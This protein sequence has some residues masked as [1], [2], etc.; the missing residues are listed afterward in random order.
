MYTA[1]HREVSLQIAIIIILL[2]LS[3]AFSASETAFTSLSMIQKKRL[4]QDRSAMGKMAYGICHK[5]DDLITTVLVGN[6]IVNIAESALVTS[7]VIDLF[8]NEFVAIATGI[9]TVVILIFGE[10]F[11]KQFALNHNIGVA[12]VMSFPLRFFQIILFPVVWLFVKISKLFTALFSKHKRDN[13]LSVD[14]LFD[15]IDVAK[16]EGV[17]DSY[18]QDLVQRVLHFN[19]TNVK[20]IMTHRTEVFSVEAGQTVRQVFPQIVE[21]KYSRIPVYQDTHENIVGVLLVRDIQKCLI[22]DHSDRL[23]SELMVTPAFIP[24]SMKVDELFRHFKKNKLQMAVVL[25]EYGGL[26][27]VVSMEDVTEQLLGEIYDEYETGMAERIVPNPVEKG[28]FTVICE[29]SFQEFLDEFGFKSEN[30]E[31]Y[32]TVA[33]YILDQAGF[34]PKIGTEVSTPLGK[35]TVTG[36]KGHKLERADFIPVSVD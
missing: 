31:G 21:R 6:N 5:P 16:D 2:V 28:V 25:D 33:S 11:P 3:A 34:I 13:D 36:I 9:L 27:G 15:V 12:K 32:S 29:V 26:S 19:E 7:F 17:V 14:A 4:E 23:V 35:F 22:N 20:A 10:I 1:T 30:T 18:E 24:E 8:G